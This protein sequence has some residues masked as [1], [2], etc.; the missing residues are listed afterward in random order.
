MVLLLPFVWGTT[1]LAVRGRGHLRAAFGVFLRFSF[2]PGTALP[3]EMLAPPA[4]GLAGLA[5]VAVRVFAASYFLNTYGVNVSQVRSGV[6]A[7]LR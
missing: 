2:V 1:Q 7:L 3:L 6:D 5:S 4:G